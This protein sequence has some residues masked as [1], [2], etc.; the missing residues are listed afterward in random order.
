MKTPEI[1]LVKKA[2]EVRLRDSNR[3]IENDGW[4]SSEGS[5]PIQARKLFAKDYDVSIDLV[6]SR[7]DEDSDTVLFQGSEVSRYEARRRIKYDQNKADRTAKVMAFPADTLFY[8]QKGY[9]GNCVLFWAEGGAGYTT[10]IDRAQIFKRDRILNEFTQYDYE[11]KIWPKPEVD[12]K[13]RLMLDSQDLD[14]KQLC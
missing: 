10:R 5:T 2:Y 7:R 8:V 3:F 4:E 14:Q 9:V 12:A 13:L 1:T 11:I 6:E